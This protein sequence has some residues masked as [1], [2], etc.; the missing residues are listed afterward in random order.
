MVERGRPV[1]LEHEV[2]DPRRA[3]PDHRKGEQE[4]GV[5]RER[6]RRERAKHRRR[7]EIVERAVSRIA[8]GVNVLG[9]ELF[10]GLHRTFRCGAVGRRGLDDEGVIP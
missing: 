10:E 7:P 6:G 5:E 4:G 2:T 9:P 3:V 1:L 8:V